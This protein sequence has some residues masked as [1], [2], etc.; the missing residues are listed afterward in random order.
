D[1]S[2]SHDAGKHRRCLGL[3]SGQHVLVDAQGESRVGVAETLADH[4]YRDPGPQ[5]QSGMRVAKP[6]KLD[7]PNAR[8]ANEAVEPLAQLVGI[9]EVAVFAAEDKAR[10]GVAAAPSAL[11]LAL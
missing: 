5:H 11:L 7:S 9:D 2:R 8:A 6:V 3:H 4:L 1:H 10:V